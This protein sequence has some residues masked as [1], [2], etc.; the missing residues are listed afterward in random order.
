MDVRAIVIVGAL[1]DHD[2]RTEA[3]ADLPLALVHVLGRP[4]LQHLI[5]RLATQGV[6]GFAVIS[7]TNLPPGSR[8]PRHDRAPVTWSYAAGP[9]LW[10]AAES[11]FIEHMQN[12]ADEVLIVRMGAYTEFELDAF[13]QAHIDGP[14]H[15]TRAADGNG[16]PMDILLVSA[17]RRNE[18]AYLFRH[19]LQET[20]SYCGTWTFTG[21][22]NR[23]ESIRDLRC[24]AVDG[25]LE[26]NRIRPA[27]REVRPG[28]W[29]GRRARLERGARILA[30]AYVG[31]R[32]RIRRNAV[33]TRCSVVEQYAQI[34][35]GS[36]VED[37]TVLPYSYIGPGLD[38]SRA[39]V[40][41]HRIASLERNIEVL[42]EDP[43]LIAAIPLSPAVR[44]M[45]SLAALTTFLPAQV[46]RGLF[47]RRVQP[48]DLSSAV[49]APSSLNTPPGFPASPSTAEVT[50]L[51]RTWQ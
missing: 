50:S 25:L 28:V 49:T 17:S 51:Q 47:T 13:L 3:F 35:V 6:K 21:Y 39:V 33:V 12:G 38:I 42:V 37:A 16:V 18:A 43:R 11:A 30:P 34:D 10:R 41:S 36:V 14:G 48:S 2:G 31:D 19:Q 46:V 29:V 7:E 45:A 15:V 23:L 26:R 8:C 1:P 20:R 27:G 44:T 40:G 22:C 5:D 9:Q 4:A 24:L 32:A